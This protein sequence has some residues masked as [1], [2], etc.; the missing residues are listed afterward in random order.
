MNLEEWDQH[1]SIKDSY[2]VCKRQIVVL[3][4][5]ITIYY[6]SSLIDG[7]QAI[8]VLA[9]LLRIPHSYNFNIEVLKQNLAHLDVSLLDF[10]KNYKQIEEALLLG[11]LLIFADQDVL[12]VDI[13]KYPVRAIS[14]PDTEKVI[15]GAHDGFNES[16]NTNIGLLRRKIKDIN[17]RTEVYKIGIDS[18]TDICLAYIDG[19]CDEALLLDVK[20]RIKKANPSHLMMTDK[21]LEE[22]L[23]KQKFNP[24]PLVRYTER[25]D[26]VAVHLYQGMFA[27]F[28]DTSPSVILAPATFFDHIQHTEEY[29]QTPLSGTFLRLVRFIGVFISLFLTPLWLLYLKSNLTFLD[30]LRPT[31]L[32]AVPISAQ[33]LISEISI[34]F[35]RMASIHTPSALSTA[36]GLIAGFILGDLA[37]SVNIFSQ[38]TVLIVAISA[39]GTYVT[40]SY[41]LGLANKLAKLFFIIAILIGNFYGF[42]IA[43]TIWFI[44]LLRLKSFNKPYLSPLFPLRVKGLLKLMIRYPSKNVKEAKKCQN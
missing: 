29:R 33:I 9:S 16:L 35:L 17:L 24:Y 39:I 18:S 22:L 44:I 10:S 15:R 20:A 38:V 42:C 36:M 6:V 31:E 7:I 40:P 3:N 37:V 8:E 41:E 1:L 21:S 28:V 27:I 14:E 34:E 26:I 2:D 5:T 32:P 11:V 13:R 25:A 23:L 30:I 4:K 43:L 12:T 19:L